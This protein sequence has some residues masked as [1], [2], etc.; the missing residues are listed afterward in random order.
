MY[1]RGVGA[2]SLDDVLAAAGAGKG[3]LYHYFVDK[4]DLVGA[5]IERQLELI[6]AEQQPALDH[7][8]SWAGIDTWASHYL[9]LHAAP[10]GPF[11][12][13][14]GTMA[15]EL[16]NDE[17]FRPSLD[18]AFRRWEAPLARGLQS[19]KDRGDLV[20]DTDPPRLAAMVIATLQGGMLVARIRD[21]VTV[22]HDAMNSAL[23]E[24]RRWQATP[25]RPVKRTPA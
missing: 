20:A 25:R 10:D 11:A 16:K 14:L 19:M 18:A 21:D 24:L 5:V 4:A 8:D 23:A 22:L 9:D 17:T 7:T 15:A 12:C 1:E 2:T 13:P 3:Q 6:L